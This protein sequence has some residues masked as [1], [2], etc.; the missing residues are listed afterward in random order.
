MFRDV[1]GMTA[2]HYAIQKNHAECANLLQRLAAG[3][4]RKQPETGKRASRPQ[5]AIS[6]YLR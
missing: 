1:N 4:D 5:S 2:L 3:S 6:R